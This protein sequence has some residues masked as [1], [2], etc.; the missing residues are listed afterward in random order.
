MGDARVGGKGDTV[1]RAPASKRT[2]RAG[3]SVCRTQDRLPPAQG[4][5]GLGGGGDSGPQNFL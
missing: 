1:R 2:F 4:G 5:A 3:G